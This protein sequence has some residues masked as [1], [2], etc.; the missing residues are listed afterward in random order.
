MSEMLATLARKTW[1]TAIDC[2]ILLRILLH[3]DDIKI[4]FFPFP[5]VVAL[6]QNGRHLALGHIDNARAGCLNYY[7][8]HKV[9]LRSYFDT[10][11]G[12]HSRE[13]YHDKVICIPA[14]ES[15]ALA[16]TRL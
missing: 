10:E 13:G 14:H 11:S 6:L 16:Q 5:D 7:G 4:V 15:T 9:T 8:L 3:I 12:L 1:K 2:C